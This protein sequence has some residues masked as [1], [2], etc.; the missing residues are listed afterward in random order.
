M[1][2]FFPPPGSLS[3]SPQEISLVGAT[4]TH[5]MTSEGHLVGFA[6][7]LVHEEKEIRYRFTLPKH[8]RL[9]HAIF[10]S[11]GVREIPRRR[12]M[13][14]IEGTYLVD[15]EGTLIG[16]DPISEGNPHLVF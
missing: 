11:S 15:V 10:R 8:K 9:V 4:V 14:H 7:K 2:D 6:V 13:F 1:P 12:E 3:E 5:V 16:E